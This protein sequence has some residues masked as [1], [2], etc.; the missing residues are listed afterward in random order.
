MSG[1]AGGVLRLLS[2]VVVWSVL[3]AALCV[4]GPLFGGSHDRYPAT[5]PGGG[6]LWSATRG[7]GDGWPDASHSASGTLSAPRAGSTTYAVTFTETGLP[8]GM[9]W[10]V[11]L[12]G[13]QS[14][15][16]TTGTVSFSEP[17][18]TYLYAATA[19][20]TRYT[21]TNGSFTVDGAA[22]SETAV[23]SGPPSK[24]T[25]TESGLPW[26]TAWS[27]SLGGVT[28]NSTTSEIV[29]SEL[30]GT[31]T[32]TVGAVAGYTALPSTGTVVVSGSPVRVGETFSP[33]EPPP[34]SGFFGMSDQAG[35]LLVGGLATIVAVVVTVAIIQR[36]RKS[37]RSPPR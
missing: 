36:E 35:D 15:S 19:R 23:F 13:G 33:L 20:D 16:T 25:F 26:R 28:L 11:N 31:Y 37:G 3:L 18:G 12:T 17:N 22:L 2:R 21:A 6:P 30:N 4:G 10:W 7:S 27:M 32:Y 9:R 8:S 5:A 29:F 24:V 1:R 14:F 34:S